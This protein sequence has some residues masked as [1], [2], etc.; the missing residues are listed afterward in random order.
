M[1]ETAAEEKNRSMQV[2]GACHGVNEFK[3][4]KR[5][6]EVVTMIAAL[7]GKKLRGGGGNCFSYRILKHPR[8]KRAP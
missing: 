6:F 7:L 2:H 8:H 1:G 4:L 3:N 5:F